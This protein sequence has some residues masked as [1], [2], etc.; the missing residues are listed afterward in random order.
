MCGGGVGVCYKK[1]K[2]FF[3]YQEFLVT[4][5]THVRSPSSLSTRETTL[6][7]LFNLQSVIQFICV[8]TCLSNRVSLP[9][10]QD[11]PNLYDML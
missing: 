1:Q 7:R 2:M 6:R 10:L 8:E 3:C 5:V 4:R 9:C 11:Y